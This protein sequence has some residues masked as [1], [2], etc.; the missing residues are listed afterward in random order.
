MLYLTIP[1]NSYFYRLSGKFGIGT[2]WH[3]KTSFGG[4]TSMFVCYTVMPWGL[5]FKMTHRPKRLYNFVF[6]R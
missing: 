5:Y 4:T 1:K 2:I 3:S 6:G